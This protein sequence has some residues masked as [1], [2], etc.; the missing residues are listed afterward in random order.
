MGR[1]LIPSHAALNVHS[2]TAAWL[3]AFS[4]CCFAEGFAEL[5]DYQF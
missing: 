3:L 4:T 1:L 5:G 2:S